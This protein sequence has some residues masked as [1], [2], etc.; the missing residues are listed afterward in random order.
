[1]S[2]Y[3]FISSEQFSRI[4]FCLKKEI[5]LLTALSVSAIF[6]KQIK[7]EKGDNFTYST[8]G[9]FLFQSGKLRLK[10]E[11][12]LRTLLG[13]QSFRSVCLAMCNNVTVSSLNLADNMADNEPDCMFLSLTFPIKYQSSAK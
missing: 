8:V 13:P 1:V 5:T 10:R 9:I 2:D 11:I 4:K 7:T 12:T 3:R 6:I